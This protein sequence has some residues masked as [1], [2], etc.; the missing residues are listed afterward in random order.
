MKK[1]TDYEVL[2]NDTFYRSWHIFEYIEHHPNMSD[3]DIEAIKATIMDALVYSNDIDPLREVLDFE[4]MCIV[5][6]DDRKYY[7]Y[8]KTPFVSGIPMEL[9]EKI[10]HKCVKHSGSAPVSLVYAKPAGG[11]TFCIYDMNEIFSTIFDKF[12]FVEVSYDSPTR[13]GI[14]AVKRPFLQV[15]INGEEYYV[16]SLTKRIFKVEEFLER[17]NGVVDDVICNLDFTSE[18]KK[19]YKERSTPSCDFAF[20]LLSNKDFYEGLNYGK[21]AETSYEY[22]K[23]KEIYPEEWDK[24]PGIKAHM[25]SVMK[26]FPKDLFK[27]LLK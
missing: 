15:N 24:I 16:D 4:N 19:V 7:H 6:S 25:D 2:V 3:L 9:K 1:L 18:M 10:R 21:F 12:S 27:R 22:N 17:Y 20:F 26:D 14:R 5:T 11:V 8:N 13:K 23:T